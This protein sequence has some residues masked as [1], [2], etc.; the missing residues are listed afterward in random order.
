M[1]LNRLYAGIAIAAM[2]AGTM[3]PAASTASA[4]EG[5]DSMPE[6]RL[7]DQVEWFVG[8]LDGSEAELTEEVVREH[9][10]PEFLAAIPVDDFIQTIEP[11]SSM[12]G[13]FTIGD[14]L[15]DDSG[16]QARVELIS[17]S[18]TDQIFIMMLEPDSGLIQGLQIQPGS[19]VITEPPGVASPAA[20]PM[21]SPAAVA[22]PSMEDVLPQ[23]EAVEDELLRSG[24]EAVEQILAGERPESEFISQLETDRVHF[25]FAEVGAVFDGHFTPTSISG[26]YYQLGPGAFQLAPESGQTGDVPT[27]RWTG[28]ILVQGGDLGIEVEFSG[29]ADN[30]TATLDIPDQNVQDQSLTNASFNAEQPIGELVTE[31]VLPLGVPTNNYSYTAGY[32]WAGATLAIVVGFDANGEVSAFNS[33][34]YWPPPEDP[35]PEASSTE[36]RLPFEGAWYVIWGGD[37]ELT[38]Y[39]VSAPNQRHAYDIAIWNDGA[40]YSGDGT[41]NEQYYAWGQD[42]LA[43]ADGTAVSVMNDQMDV[44]PSASGESTPTNPTTHPAGNHVVIQTGENEFVFIAHMQQ[45]SVN[46]EEG[47]EVV[48]GDVLGLVGNSGN[49]SEPHIHI[50]A[51]NEQEFSLFGAIGLPLEFTDYIADGEPVDRGVPQQGELIAPAE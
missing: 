13:E 9:F 37:T 28:A 6:G 50:H 4:Q 27:G 49:S 48:T 20:S 46:V 1:K 7:R 21:A 22:P 16:T 30:L 18:G 12:L 32:D 45:G 34:A 2:L 44:P 38:N 23:L 14:V 11:L 8:V 42:V 10:T 29:D 33:I 15:F 36:Y 19:G 24:R 5:L 47:D 26:F 17:D 39:H 43:P 51:Q 40:T 31:R 3:L 35:A 25:E 41:M